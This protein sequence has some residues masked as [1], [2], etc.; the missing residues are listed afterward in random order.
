MVRTDGSWR[1]LTEDGALEPV[2]PQPVA[3]NSRNPG[4]AAPMKPAVP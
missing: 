3:E 4:R 1:C 2:S